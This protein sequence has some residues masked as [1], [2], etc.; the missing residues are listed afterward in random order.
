MI[1]KI[2]NGKWGHWGGLIEIEY[3][4]YLFGKVKYGQFCRIDDYDRVRKKQSRWRM[5]EALKRSRKEKEKKKKRNTK[6]KRRTKNKG[7]KRK[8]KT[9][10][11]IS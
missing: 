4:D 10:R 11:E 3:D 7:K 6:T 1:V 8:T 2:H 5:K 9:I